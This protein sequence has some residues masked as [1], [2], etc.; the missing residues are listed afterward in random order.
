M[1][2]T[3]TILGPNSSMFTMG[4]G[5]TQA[6]VFAA[7][8]AYVSAH[9]WEV[10]DAAPG[11]NLTGNAAILGRVY[12]A[13]QDGSTS[14]YKYVAMYFT[15]ATASANMLMKVFESWNATTHVG[16][17][18]GAFVNGTNAVYVP[19]Q[20]AVEGSA[21]ILFVNKKW[22]AFRGRDVNYSYTAF[23]GAFE[24]K[25]DFGEPE[26]LPT[27]ILMCGG[28]NVG[29]L[30]SSAINF[31]GSPRTSKGTVGQAGSNINTISTPFGVLGWVNNSYNVSLRDIQPQ[32]YPNGTMT[33][34]AAENRVAGS[35]GIEKMRGRIFGIKLIYGTVNWNDMDKTQ[36]ATDS[37]FFQNPGSA[38]MDHHCVF[39]TPSNQWPTAFARFAIPV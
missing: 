18:E 38:L 19:I 17:N 11:A 27:V 20:Y 3:E 13:L 25:K 1:A 37:E 10:H 23:I 24:I 33:M 30:P 7:I 34:T 28:Q 8:D 32:V 29:S 35:Y 31:F 36:I 14:V 6:T 16:V 39:Y 12:R 22:L 21:L 5:E 9:G 4:A 15:T 26:S 2:I